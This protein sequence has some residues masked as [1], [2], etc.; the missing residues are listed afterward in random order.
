MA[1][2]KIE[3]VLDDL[4]YDVIQKEITDYQVHCRRIAPA[5]PTI[6]PDGESNLA[7]AIIAECVRSLNEYRKMFEKT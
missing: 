2:R 7:G 3:L 4:D 5:G 6:L 1:L